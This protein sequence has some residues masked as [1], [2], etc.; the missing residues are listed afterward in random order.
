MNEDDAVEYMKKNLHDSNHTQVGFDPRRHG[1]FYCRKT[2]RPLESAEHVI[3][4]GP[5][6]LAK[7][8][9]FK[10]EF[11][12]YADGGSAKKVY[13]DLRTDFKTGGEARIKVQN[14]YLKIHAH[15]PITQWPTMQKWLDKKQGK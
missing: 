8:A 2:M 10:K 5:L 11:T 1:E 3:Q 13:D 4:V 12:T 15:L 14:E 9:K 6:V 7:N